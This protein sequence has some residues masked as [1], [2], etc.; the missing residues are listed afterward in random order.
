MLWEP[1]TEGACFRWRGAHRSLPGGG[2][3]RQGWKDEV[4]LFGE[5]TVI[6]V[7]LMAPKL[8]SYMSG[9]NPWFT[10]VSFA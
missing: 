9:G 5:D 1:L 4:Q 2:D 3:R 10:G 7:S 8:R 6:G